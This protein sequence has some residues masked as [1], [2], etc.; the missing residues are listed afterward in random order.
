MREI[1]QAFLLRRAVGALAG[2]LLALAPCDIA[3]AQDCSG[4][5]PWINEIDYDSDDPL[6]T[7]RD[8]FVEIAAPVGSDLGGYRV[9]SVEGQG[10]ILS[11]CLT[12]APFV[13]T[14][15][16][17]FSGVLPGGT[18][19]ARH[20]GTGIGFVVVCFS[21][22]SA[23]VAASGL[24]DV[25]IAGDAMDSNLRNGDL[26]N[27]DPTTCPDG[28]V[29]QSADQSHTEAL[30][31]EGLIPNQG[32]WGPYFGLIDIGL[33]PGDA[34]SESLY[35]TTSTAGPT[36]SG[37]EWSPGGA[38]PGS[39]NPGQSLVCDPVCGNGFVEAGEACD[40]GNATPED[41]C[42]SSCAPEFCGDGV[43]QAGLGETC[44]DGNSAS[45]DG[46]SAL[47]QAE[48]CGDG[49][50]QGG[51]GEVCDDGNGD[52]FDLCR[53]DCQPFPAPTL[54]GWGLLGLV[55]LMT[56]AGSAFLRRS[57]RLGGGDGGRGSGGSARR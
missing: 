11:L 22:T 28:V 16:A 54:D 39:E 2:A 31:W 8:E 44:D 46:C 3:L 10:N 33:D 41:G 24:C 49:V 15:E 29:L 53:N 47:C 13:F 25:T 32:P 19:A 52:D 42:S 27:L 48:F 57:R 51:L 5:S 20:N 23:N 38:T 12:Q 34:A 45:E 17:H 14:G 21:D 37:S 56:T 7:D 4:V 6:L 40:D 30:S 26:Q 36:A 50:V 55:L 35:K 1:D 43:V 18:V 9:V